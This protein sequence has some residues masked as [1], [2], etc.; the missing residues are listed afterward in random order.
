[1]I[2][3]NGFDHPPGLRVRRGF[4]RLEVF[5]TR[6]LSG[7]TGWRFS[8]G[9]QKSITLLS[10]WEEIR[11]ALARTGGVESPSGGRGGVE[12][13]TRSGGGIS[14][15]ENVCCKNTQVCVRFVWWVA[16]YDP[17]RSGVE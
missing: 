10:C 9:F 15:H 11:S 7:P 16:S 13:S 12:G 5:L 14:M 4:P 8:H 2:G 17:K 6:H 3:L 1:V